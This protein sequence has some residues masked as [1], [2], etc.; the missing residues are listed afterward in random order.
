MERGRRLSWTLFDAEIIGCSLL[1]VKGLVR[2]VGESP[3]VVLAWASASWSAA[4][5]P[6]KLGKTRRPK[7][8]TNGVAEPEAALSR[9]KGL[10]RLVAV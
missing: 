5:Q 6:G 7:V 1:I 2:V 9:S 10:R 8:I 4:A 3:V